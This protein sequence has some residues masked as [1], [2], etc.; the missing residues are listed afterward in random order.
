M[1]DSRALN[2]HRFDQKR[3]QQKRNTRVYN[4]KN[5]GNTRMSKAVIDQLESIQIKGADREGDRIGVGDQPRNLLPDR[6][7]GIE[8]GQR[9]K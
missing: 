1:A 9:E 4:G 7:A 6:V 3:N 5:S 2:P 8:P